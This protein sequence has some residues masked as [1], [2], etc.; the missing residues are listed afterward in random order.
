MRYLFP[1]ILIALSTSFARADAVDALDEVNAAR[2]SL[3]LPAFV[4]DDGLTEAA[5]T[6]ATFRADRGL[7]GHSG[8]DFAALPAGCTADAAGC[9]CWPQGM[10]WGACCTYEDYS[11]AGAAVVVRSGQ[12]YMHIFVAHRQSAK[13]PPAKLPM[14]TATHPTP[15]VAPVACSSCSVSKTTVR[16]RTRMRAHQGRRGKCRR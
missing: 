5:K 3:G 11:H 15:V 8:N 9:A 10:G 12:R 4:R 6:L 14:P 2:A 16:V 1:L 7:A 13:P